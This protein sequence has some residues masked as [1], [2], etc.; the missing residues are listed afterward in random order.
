MA[1]EI[2]RQKELKDLLVGDILFLQSYD[3]TGMVR[4]LK[5]V[6]TVL[7]KKDKEGNWVGDLEI[8]VLPDLGVA[9]PAKNVIPPEEAEKIRYDCIAGISPEGAEDI[10]K[11]YAKYEELFGYLTMVTMISGDISAKVQSAYEQAAAKQSQDALKN[12]DII[13]PS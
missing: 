6:V 2:R 12:P 8:I 10:A 1:G 9:V 13:L 4:L 7:P 5:G 3:V 11:G